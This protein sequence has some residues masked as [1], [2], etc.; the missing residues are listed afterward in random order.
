M[1]AS[2]AG[3]WRNVTSCL[4]E[5]LA[6]P[7]FVLAEQD[8]AELREPIGAF[9]ERSQDP[10]AVGD[11]QRDD[12]ALGVECLL[13][14]ACGWFADAGAQLADELSF[15]GNP[16]EPRHPARRTYVRRGVT[17]LLLCSRHQDLDGDGLPSDLRHSWKV[18]LLD[19]PAFGDCAAEFFPDLW[20]LED[21]DDP[22]LA[23]REV[24]EG[25]HAGDCHGVPPTTF[26]L[27]HL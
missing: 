26:P 5:S 20:R 1:S 4:D 14:R 27:A 19:N 2:V 16:S 22:V 7:P 8:A 11:R 9:L 13:E 12:C 21:V 3:G 10:L 24:D 17:D 15:D 23:V 18:D 6:E 25:V